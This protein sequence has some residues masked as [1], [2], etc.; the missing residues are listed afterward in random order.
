MPDTPGFLQLV[1]PGFDDLQA[2]GHEDAITPSSHT[3]SENIT[4][5]NS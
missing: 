3:T 1:L 5:H 2:V 4:L